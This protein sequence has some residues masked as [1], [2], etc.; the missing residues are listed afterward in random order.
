[1]LRGG[2]TAFTRHSEELYD[3]ESFAL[4]RG[5][6]PHSVRNDIC[7]IMLQADSTRFQAL[8]MAFAGTPSEWLS[9]KCH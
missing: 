8:A 4:G 2:W 3:E 7:C 9:P 5:K 6:I 1:M